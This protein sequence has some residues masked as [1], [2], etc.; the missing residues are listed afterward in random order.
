MKFNYLMIAA[1]LFMTALTSCDLE[2]VLDKVELNQDVTVNEIFEVNLTA[3][4]PTTFSEERT[5]STDVE[6][7]EIT[8][9]EISEL[10]YTV[11]NY[12]GDP[13]NL[14]LEVW[15]GDNAEMGGVT[16]DGA[17]LEN[18]SSDL[19][20]LVSNLILTSWEN[21]LLGNPEATVNVSATIDEVPVTFDLALN[22]TLKVTGT[23]K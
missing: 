14:S 22:M 13:Q 6:G 10:T 16:V 11:S 7:L 21:Y 3:N 20:L 2:D 19:L 8:K 17:I 4:D 12:S 1:V 9:I 18:G 23:K 15:F 5:F